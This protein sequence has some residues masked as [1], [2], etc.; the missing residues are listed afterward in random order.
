MVGEWERCEAVS[1]K[2][3]SGASIVTVIKLSK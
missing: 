3:G 2:G 1:R